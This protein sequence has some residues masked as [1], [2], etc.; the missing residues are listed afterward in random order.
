MQ[1]KTKTEDGRRTDEGVCRGLRAPAR[2]EER[3]KGMTLTQDREMLVVEFAAIGTNL[4]KACKLAS[5]L[6]ACYARLLDARKN[7]AP[8]VAAFEEREREREALALGHE[9]SA[10][11]DD[12]WEAVLRLS[13]CYEG[14]VEDSRTTAQEVEEISQ[15]M[16]TAGH[17]LLALLALSR[18][19]LIAQPPEVG[20]RLGAII[21]R[22]G[23]VSQQATAEALC[24]FIVD[25]LRRG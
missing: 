24:K 4:E 23:E 19:F 5:R 12:T 6:S 22:V 20:E 13:A 15:V 10:I 9:F 21:A 7:A 2:D 17:A 8:D 25:E 16:P 18:V 3:S 1:G 14:F 11:I